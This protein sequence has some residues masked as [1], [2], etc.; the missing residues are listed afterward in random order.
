M[1]YVQ[2]ASA[3]ANY[4]SQSASSSAVDVASAISALQVNPRAQIAIQDSAANIE[5]YFDN[6]KTVSNNISS[7]TLNDTATSVIHLT[8]AQWVQGANLL[9]KMDLGS[10]SNP[11]SLSVS[12]V[13]SKDVA[14]VNANAQVSQF[15]VRDTTANVAAKWSDLTAG[16]EKLGDVQLTDPGKAVKLSF[17]QYSD[18]KDSL[19]T[20]FKGTFAVNLTGASATDALTTASDT[21]V[22]LVSITDHAQAIVDNLDGLQAM[23]LKVKS[24]TSD[25]TSVFKVSADELQLDKAVIGKLYKGYQLAV[26]NVDTYTAANLK[27]NK[28]VI[29]LDIADTADNISKHLNFL[30]KLGSQL[31]TVTVTDS[32]ALK[33]GAADFFVNGQVL[34]KITDPSTQANTYQ[35]AVVDA[36]AVDAK[37]LKDNSHVQSIVVKDSSAAI[38]QNID[39]LNANTL[40]TGI[41]Q[42]G[43]VA[44]L[45]I[46]ADQLANDTGALALIRGSHSF[47]VRGVLAAN[48]KAL[49]EDKST[50]NVTSVSVTDTGANIVAKLGELTSMGKTVSS[51]VQ[52]T[53]GQTNAEQAL[54]LTASDWMKH[55]GTLSKIVGGYG[56]KVSAVSAAKA[57][58]IAT[59]LRVRSFEVSDTGAAIAANIDTLQA[60]GAKLSAI[61]QS[62][63]SAIQISGAQYAA[64]AS[65]L[66]K[67]GDSYTLSVA[68]ARASQVTTLAADA[69]HVQTIGVADTVANIGLNLAAIQTAITATDAPAI[70]IAMQGAPTAFTLSKTQFADNA[71]ALNAIQGNYAV[72]VTGLST[73][74]AVG[75]ASNT[76]VVGMALDASAANLSNAATLAQLGALGGKLSSINQ[77]D[78]GTSLTLS[79]ADWSSNSGVLNKV[80]GY[81]VALTDVQ[82]ASADNLLTNNPQVVSVAVTDTAAEI[83][84]SFSQLAGLGASLQG[85]TQASRDTGHLQLSMAQWS[86]ASSTLAKISGSYSVDISRASAQQAQTLVSD[87]TIASVGVVGSAFD[88]SANL[89]DL[90]A[91]GK[92]TSLQ[93]SDP[94]NP[95]S[96]TMAQLTSDI[97]GGNLLG[98]IQGGYR[99]ALTGVG[100]AYLGAVAAQGHVT[101]MDVTGSAGDIEGG[102]HALLAAG[103]RLKS[104]TLSG[105]DP[106]VTVGYSDFKKYSNVL[107]MIKQPFSLLVNDVTASGVDALAQNTVF[108][109]SMTVSDSAGNIATNWATLANLGSQIS[110]I[111]T[112]ETAPVLNLTADQYAG[113][114]G[115][116]E[117]INVA[118]GAPNYKVA[119][120]GGDVNFARN[121]LADSAASAHLQS[122]DILDSANNISGNFD[123]LQ[124]SKIV[125]IHLAPGASVLDITGSQYASSA[126]LAKVKTPFSLN[127]KAAAPADANTLQADQRVDAFEVSATAA[128]IGST[129]PD[130]LNLSH[131]THVDITQS[132]G[133]TGA[134]LMSLTAEQ[135]AASQDNLGKVRGNYALNVTGVSMATLDG[136]SGKN[137][138]AGIQ[139]SDSSAAVAAGWDALAALGDQLTGIQLTTQDPVAITLDQWSQSAGALSKLQSDQ[140]LALLDVPVDQAISVAAYTNVATVAV[141]G[142]ANQVASNFDRL[143]S[144]GAQLDDIE[145]TDPTAPLVLTQAQADAGSATLRK[146]NGGMNLQ[147]QSS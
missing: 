6:L 142:S 15:S 49:L 61:S 117:K 4:Y 65:T 73:A 13:Q 32:A 25:D 5:K 27:P 77:S 53:T 60:V 41:K 36:H 16:L 70:S 38:A 105:T 91:N 58:G 79:A 76:H 10:G 37:V 100:V 33:V 59:D 55:I 130:L 54:Q 81:S 95:I 84:R 111:N 83:S 141:K 87:D 118:N 78:A 57:M 42:S 46:T 75:L 114:S 90:L 35:L 135:Y 131:L 18:A 107:S 23:G 50:Y 1:M 52:D 134:A 48:A 66:S 86:T 140:P 82:A 21:R 146:V 132:A 109:S 96:M 129:L 115:M 64:N 9:A 145:L 72:N 30:N 63:S 74:D 24:M 143:V 69:A 136:I 17:S 80:E 102:L 51:I 99:L 2:S 47:N 133:V 98:K 94:T 85:I 31:N 12:N 34:D 104:L 92:V 112:T 113:S 29:S 116:L 93:L 44:A 108:N 19:L 119:L 139:V 3:T 20:H 126:S 28:K 121:L 97:A 39:D 88:V 68:N 45:S 43:S 101:G 123:L 127:V 56:V 138:V 40:L 11:V 144:L 14:T 122:V 67:L 89:G 71:D 137:N 124:N 26:F 106:T 147:I 8:S 128:Q 62:D 125:G 110:A 120:T 22:N 7:V 103:P